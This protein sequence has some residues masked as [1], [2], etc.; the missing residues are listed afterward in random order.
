MSSNQRKTI[1]HAKSV[2]SSL[3]KTFEKQIITIEDQGGKQLKALE[4]HG[5][6]L[7]QSMGEKRL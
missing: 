3:D 1:K 2:N 5:K 7:I 4:E 6:Q